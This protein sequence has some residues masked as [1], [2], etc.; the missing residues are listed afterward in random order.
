MANNTVQALRIQLNMLTS[1]LFPSS[2]G[3]AHYAGLVI[4]V[5]ALMKSNNV[6]FMIQD[7]NKFPNRKPQCAIQLHRPAGNIP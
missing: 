4:S 5:M 1:L 6:T 7:M 2:A 3:I